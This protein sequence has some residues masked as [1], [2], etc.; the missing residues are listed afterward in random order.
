[1]SQEILTVGKAARKFHV[2]EQTIR[3]W[4]EQGKLE[5]FRTPSGQ[6]RIVISNIQETK[7]DNEQRYKAV[8]CRVSSQKQ[9]DDLKRQIEFMQKNYQ[10][11][12]VF[13]D[14]GSGI[15]FKRRGLIT[16]LDEA[17]NGM[18]EEVVVFSRDRLCRFAFELFEWFFKRSGT[19]LTVIN[20]SDDSPE[21]ELSEDVLS[22]IQVFCCRRNGKRRYNCKESQNKTSPD[23]KSEMLAEEV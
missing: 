20:S 16:L 11:Y 9:K 4:I 19:K 10:G 14:V 13:Q 6:R 15:N 1:M 5:S 2:H 22:I 18:V 12:K 7:E 21:S 8:Y 23:Q 3:T 17:L